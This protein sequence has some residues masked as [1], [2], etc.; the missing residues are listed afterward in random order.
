MKIRPLPIDDAFEITPVTHSDRRGSYMEL[1]RFDRLAE[2]VGHPL[3]MAQ[4]NVAVSTAGAMRG[5]HYADVPPGQAKYITCVRGGGL[6]VII[7]LRVGSPT[8]GQHATVELND[9]DRRAV[10]LGEGLGHAFCADQDDSVLTYVCSAVYNPAREHA[11]NPMDPALGITW[12][13]PEPILSEKDATAPTLAEARERGL[14]PDYAEC[15]RYR[16]EL[17]DTLAAVT[18]QP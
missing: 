14:L 3:R 18:A 7:D 10:Y 17:S 5:I 9:T 12:P 11:I 15:L 6:D 16:A 13:V 4:W 8:F 2:H 1:Y